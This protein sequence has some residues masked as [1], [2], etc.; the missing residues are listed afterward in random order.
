[1]A[2][3]MQQMLDAYAAG[4]DTALEG[5]AGGAA[6]APAPEEGAPPVETPAPEAP[7]PEPA[8]Q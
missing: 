6:P 2:A 1:M 7:A 3:D 5:C 8:P 4:V